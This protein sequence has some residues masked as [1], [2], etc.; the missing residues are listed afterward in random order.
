MPDQLQT[1]LFEIAGCFASGQAVT[2]I[3]PLGNG[4][5]NDTFCVHLESQSRFVLQ[6]INQNVFREPAKV[7]HNMGLLSAHASQAPTSS[8]WRLPGVIYPQSG[9]NH[10]IDPDG[11]Y[12]RA[13]SY[14]P[15]TYSVDHLEDP[16]LAFEAGRALGHF[17]ALVSNLEPELFEDTLPGF[18]HSPTYLKEYDRSP[19]QAAPTT[20]EA[21]C[22]EFVESRR[23]VF[24]CL[25]D[26]V[27]QGELKLGLMHGDP[28]I[29]NILF[30]AT[31][32]QAA[33][34]IDL[35]TVKPGLLQYDIGDCL[36]SACNPLGEETTLYGQ[37]NF[38]LG[39][40]ESILRGFCAESGEIL[41]EKAYDLFYDSTRLLTLELGLRFFTDHLNGN[42]YFKAKDDEHNLRRARVQ[43]ALCESVERQENEM[44]TITKNI[45]LEREA[46]RS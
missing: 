29:N 27:S 22:L 33:S 3:L 8:G 31:T 25:E 41:D 28:K 2:E 11:G 21:W 35:D 32:H 10:V 40:A 44:R 30:D 37:V 4:N 18:H 39:L 12:W 14:I 7:M 42:V 9:D 1:D 5:I 46:I 43:F 16:K 24:N 20:D 6:K 38:D 17:H 34:L 23:E 36:R 19:K 13:I 45:R 15:D 26:L